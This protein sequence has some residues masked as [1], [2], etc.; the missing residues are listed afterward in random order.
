MSSRALNP[1]AAAVRANVRATATSTFGRGLASAADPDASD[2]TAVRRQLQLSGVMG[3]VTSVA[4]SIGCGVVFSHLG[5]ARDV[6]E[7]TGSYLYVYS[8]LFLARMWFTSFLSL[9]LFALWNSDASQQRQG[10]TAKLIIRVRR[11]SRGVVSL[12]MPRGI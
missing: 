8:S 5:D 2:T 6:C 9:I 7:A 4:F 11:K 1:N 3:V 10:S 12:S